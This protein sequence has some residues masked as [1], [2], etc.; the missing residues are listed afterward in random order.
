M[1]GLFFFRE[2]AVPDRVVL[3]IDYFN[4]YMGARE[5]F[6]SPSAFH[7]VGQFAPIALGEL[8]ASRP[9]AGFERTLQEVRLYYGRP[10]ARR[11]PGSYAATMRQTAA[12]EAAGVTVV[13]RPL[14]YPPDWP[15][16]KKREKGIDVALAV[17]FVTMAIDGKYDVGIIF[18]T[19]TDLLPAL[20]DVLA[21]YSSYPRAETAAWSSDRANRPL[22]V[23][24]PRRN[25]C[26][27]LTKSDYES[28]RDATDYNARPLPRDA[29]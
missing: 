26:H 13:A 12:W 16:S 21:R 5:S 10:E 23:S 4:T 22:L 2:P 17:D 8:I 1:A 15:K 28:V 19:D 3:F 18:S 25:W 29:P 24:G 11:E 20:E 14:K 9:P 27:M 6:F 7:T